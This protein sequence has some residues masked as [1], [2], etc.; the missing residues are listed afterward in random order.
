MNFGL[1]V[2]VAYYIE[3]TMDLATRVFPLFDCEHTEEWIDSVL[4]K[5]VCE[6]NSLCIAGK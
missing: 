1:A 5:F 2:V 6:S 4:V 3:R